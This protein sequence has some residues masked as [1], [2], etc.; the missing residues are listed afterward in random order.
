MLQIGQ[1]VKELRKAE[2]LKQLELAEKVGVTRQVISQI[3]NDSFKGSITKLNAVLS[4][5]RYRVTIEV[6]RFPTIEEL[7]GLFDD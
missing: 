6:I 3:E 2:G 4:V 1:Q 7:D 5:L